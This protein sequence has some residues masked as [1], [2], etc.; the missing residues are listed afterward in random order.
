MNG[1]QARA[2]GDVPQVVR[3]PS[4]MT[5]NADQRDK[6]GERRSQ[7][8]GE[9]K[10]P[11]WHELLFEGHLQRVGDRLEYSKGASAIRPD[12]P[13]EAREYP[14]LDQRHVGERGQQRDDDDDALHERRDDAPRKIRHQL[15]SP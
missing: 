12:A 4:G 1:A 10:R 7:Q 2:M 15:C 14:P 13:L 9:A 8:E 5:A 11:R 3:S 6:D